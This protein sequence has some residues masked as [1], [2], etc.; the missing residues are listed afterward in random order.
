MDSSIVCNIK[1][2]KQAKCLSKWLSL[3]APLCHSAVWP[4]LEGEGKDGEDTPA[5]E[6][7]WEVSQLNEASLP[8][9]ALG[10]ALSEPIAWTVRERIAACPL[11]RHPLTQGDFGLSGFSSPL[12]IS[13]V[14]KQAG[15]LKTQFTNVRYH[16]FPDRI[17][18]FPLN[19][20]RRHL[21][22]K[23]GDEKGHV[24]WCRGW[25]S[26]AHRPDL[27]C[28]LFWCTVQNLYRWEFLDV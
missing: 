17:L 26:G 19:L 15:R 6:P 18:I 3:G 13:E 21:K 24:A 20:N 2:R 9:T 27:V 23:K 10:P 7:S 4:G 11:L 14:S 22:N 16:P 28:Y 8:T 5:L 25:Q 1:N 12:L